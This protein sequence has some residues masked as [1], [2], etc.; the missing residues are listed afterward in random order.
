MTRERDKRGGSIDVPAKWWTHVEK[1]FAAI[2]QVPGAV[3]VLV[4]QSDRMRAGGD[5]YEAAHWGNPGRNAARFTSVADSSLVVELGSLVSVTYRTAKGRDRRVEDWEH[6]FR[7]ALPV[8]CFAGNG[9]GLVIVRGQ[10]RY[11]V[12]ERGIVG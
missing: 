4:E 11:V 9:S 3:D 5:A 7:G 2:E 10:S 1:I 8:L 12:T 6:A